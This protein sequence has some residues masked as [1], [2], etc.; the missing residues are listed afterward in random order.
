MVG[1]PGKCFETREE[2]KED[3]EIK[4]I[5]VDRRVIMFQEFFFCPVTNLPT[6]AMHVHAFV[7]DP[8]GR[9]SDTLLFVSTFGTRDLV[10]SCFRLD[11]RRSVLTILV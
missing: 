2:P 5:R 4:T 6:L 8:P 10:V 3:R 7:D 11:S 9:R 1:R